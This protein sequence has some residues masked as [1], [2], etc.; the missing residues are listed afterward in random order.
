MLRARAATRKH[1]VQDMR[2]AK[3]NEMLCA[4][5]IQRK[6]YV[7]FVGSSRDVSIEENN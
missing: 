5:E 6:N 7:L 2:I 4:H 3:R 1:P